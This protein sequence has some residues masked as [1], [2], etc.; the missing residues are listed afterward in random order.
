MP[1]RTTSAVT[2]PA[3]VLVVGGGIAG[4][5]AALAAADLG[6]QVTVAGT[7]RP[8]AASRVAA[9][10]L[11][12]SLDGLAPSVRAIAI[13]ARDGYPAFL[14]HLRTSADTPV[15]LDGNGILEL[16][17]SASDL[18]H[19]MARAG[20]SAQPLGQGEL[21]QL[22]PA[23]AGHAGAV[24]HP[25]DGAVDNVAL[26]DALERAVANNGRI[27]RC[28]AQIVSFDFLAARP[29]AVTA[30]G[31]RLESA[32]ILLAAGAWASRIPG[33]PRVLPVRPVR[34]EVLCLDTTPIHHVTFGAGGYL[35]PRG[36]SLLIGATSEDA[37]FECHPSD[38]GRASLLGIA[39]GTVPSLGN[40]HIV[41]HRAGLR[42][43]TPDA[44]PILGRDPDVPAL[45]YACGFSRN[46][47]L[48]APWAATQLAD[49][50]AGGKSGDALGPFRPAR[51][52]QNK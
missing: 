31:G 11:A 7:A 17:S 12:P 19:L 38:A 49:L 6:L 5:C 41:E 48:L 3:D 18:A 30:A 45:L 34:G 24:L 50:L 28:H 43:M 52:D 2:R 25:H 15:A 42:P 46:G 37:G 26:M 20:P 1:I 40:A 35:V 21:A 14:A 9:G 32:S 8:G 36:S 27:H 23:L 51:F 39:T 4:L 22:E 29:V 44:M 33:L 16:A 47:I 10:L 13:M